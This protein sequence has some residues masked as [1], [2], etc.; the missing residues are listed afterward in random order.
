MHDCLGVNRAVRFAESI[1][2]EV[3]TVIGFLRP[4]VL[5]PASAVSGLTTQELEFVLAHEL[6][7]VRRH[8]WM[9]NLTQ[10][11]IEALLFYHPVMWWVSNEIRK[12]R[13]N[14][15]DDLAVAVCGNPP[16]CARAL[17][18][19]EELRGTSPVVALTAT[20]G[21]LL[22]RIRRLLDK[23]ARPD[24]CRYGIC[25]AGPSALVLATIVIAFAMTTGGAEERPK[26]NDV[27]A[28]PESKPEP[29]FTLT[30]LDEQD[31]P[32]PHAKVNHGRVDRDKERIHYSRTAD[33]NGVVVLDT[34]P[35]E[36]IGWF[37]FSV[38][39]PGYAPFYGQW[40]NWDSNDLP[41]KQFTVRLK[42]GKTI[43]GVVHD[44]QGEPVEGVKVEF[45]F[46]YGPD[47]MRVDDLT[48]CAASGTTDAQGRWTCGYVPLGLA[49]TERFTLNHPD[50]KTCQYTIPLSDLLPDENGAHDRV[51]RIGKGTA[52]SGTVTDKEGHP[53]ADAQVY[54]EFVDM[55]GTQKDCMR[56]TQ[57]DQDGNYRIDNCPI[58]PAIVGAISPGY[59]TRA[60]SCDITEKS[61]PVSI[62]LESERS[63]TLRVLDRQGHPI[64]DARFFVRNWQGCRWINHKLLSNDD[65]TGADGRFLWN[66]APREEMRIETSALDYIC[67]VVESVKPVGQEHV[68]KLLPTLRASGTVTDKASGQHIPKFTVTPGISFTNN[69]DKVHWQPRDLQN[70]TEGTYSIRWRHPYAGYALR[71]EAEG[72]VSEVSR[73]IEISEGTIELD[74]ALERATEE[75]LAR[76]EK[77][78]RHQPR[79]VVLRP[80]GKPAAGATLGF[81]T[82]SMG[83]YIQSGALDE[84]PHRFFTHADDRRRFTIPSLTPKDRFQRRD[85]PSTDNTPILPD[86]MVALH[87]SGFAYLDYSQIVLARDK[88]TTTFES[89][90]QLQEWARIEGRVML[91]DKPAVECPVNLQV[92]GPV[93]ADGSD[94][95]KSQSGI[96]YDY[97]A[98]TDHQGRFVLNKVPP[99]MRGSVARTI[100]FARDAGF[101]AHVASH[102]VPLLFNPGETTDVQ[103]GGNGRSVIGKLQ[104]AEGSPDPIDW[105][106]ALV[107]INA[108]P[109][110]RRYP[111][112]S[113]VDS[114]GRF[115]VEDVPPGQYVL[116]VQITNPESR[117]NHS[118]PPFSLQQDFPIVLP[119]SST[120][121]LNA[122]TLTLSQQ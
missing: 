84:E 99:G 56:E 62:M 58:G 82:E 31:N 122:G 32:V 15:C 26:Q 92:E 77:Q 87:E 73:K 88:D 103:I 100:V 97:S 54:V 49:G 29:T 6:A 116:S 12:E 71:V 51:M 16:T 33:E 120:E 50:Y 39:T 53:I 91:G 78:N 57:T 24:N 89:P 61:E 34:T 63:L 85:T 70:H 107:Q 64:E 41:P 36:N 104:Y 13:E 121:P 68:F 1:L 65:R 95:P 59:A 69:P 45:S 3:P 47:G 22:T 60:R 66:S 83:I 105:K 119:D 55:L 9:I 96:W 35:P 52:I 102:A 111:R 90:V 30:V 108:A 8:D 10:I 14:R 4:I 17:A 98:T 7:H 46:P 42:K 38:K 43:G 75:H 113:A 25:L 44:D 67:S 21:S 117:H 40:D 80:D 48:H 114:E 18:H 72:Y 110:N 81:A 20:G 11:V 94:A 115:R 19:L 79:G 5:L 86:G 112:C 74:F 106:F 109:N 23:P 118:H 93:A 37:C 101:S 27:V 76:Q 28:K 2:V